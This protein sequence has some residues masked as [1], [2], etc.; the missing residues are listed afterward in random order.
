[1]SI[2]EANYSDV[3][4]A[5]KNIDPLY[6]IKRNIEFVSQ[7]TTTEELGSKKTETTIHN[8]EVSGSAIEINVED[9]GET[10]STYNTQNCITDTGIAVLNYES[11]DS[12]ESYTFSGKTDSEK[13]LNLEYADSIGDID[14]ETLI[15]LEGVGQF[16]VRHDYWATHYFGADGTVLKTLDPT[17]QKTQTR[18]A[19]YR[20]ITSEYQLNDNE[21]F[22][23]V[24]EELDDCLSNPDFSEFAAW[25]EVGSTLVYNLF[26][27]NDNTPLE[28]VFFTPDEEAVLILEILDSEGKSIGYFSEYGYDLIMENRLL[29]TGV[30]TIYLEHDQSEELNNGVEFQLNIENAALKFKGE[31]ALP[32][33]LIASVSSEWVNGGGASS[34]ITTPGN[35][36]YQMDVKQDSIF[37]FQMKVSEWEYL[38]LINADGSLIKSEYGY[39]NNPAFIKRALQVGTYYIVAAT[40]E[41]GETGTFDI[42][43]KSDNAGSAS[44]TLYSN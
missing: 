33:N 15:D 38:Y 5:Y 16:L 11:Y 27:L 3:V 18:P 8:C 34:D 36:V 10:L 23:E 21:P 13:T 20:Q 1:M 7:V 32:S 25:S 9:K 39:N 42:T 22:I 26:V 37:T 12:R 14:N 4:D 17:T 29:D 30:Y 24:L 2:S 6:L 28:A 19:C 44:V 43:V 40:E 31:V 35:I 41:E